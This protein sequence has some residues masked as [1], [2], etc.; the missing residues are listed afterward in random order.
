MQSNIPTLLKNKEI[1]FGK[2]EMPWRWFGISFMSIW[3]IESQL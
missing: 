3:R 1:R 2:A